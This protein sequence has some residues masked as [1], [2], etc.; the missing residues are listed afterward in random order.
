MAWKD[1]VI[2][3]SNISSIST[4]PLALKQFPLW[5]LIGIFIGLLL[6]KFSALTAILFIALSV[7]CIYLWNKQNMELK[8][9]KN[10]II[11]MNSGITFSFLFK[12]EKFLNK[13]FG[14]LSSIIAEGNKGSHHVKINI[15][16]S[17]ISG[18]AN[19]LN[20]M[21]VES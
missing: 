8:S 9:Q 14:V 4:V 18:N 5:T 19:V 16:N 17:T 12:D 6:F 15:N 1:S 21:F 3:L 20:D 10:L 7:I 13:V 11:L 2:Q